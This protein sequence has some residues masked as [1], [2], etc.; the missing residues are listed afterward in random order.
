MIC[1]TFKTLQ[2]LFLNV[3][4]SQEIF[5]KLSVHE[6]DPLLFKFEPYYI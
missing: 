2:L 6:I 5:L 4:I 3:R 1:L